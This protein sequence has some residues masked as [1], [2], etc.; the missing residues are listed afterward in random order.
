MGCVPALLRGGGLCISLLLDPKVRHRENI[1]TATPSSSA[2]SLPEENSLTDTI[3]AFK[4][5]LKPSEEKLNS[6]LGS[7]GQWYDVH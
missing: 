7:K 5:S 2:S 3:A 1:L 4:D 6:V